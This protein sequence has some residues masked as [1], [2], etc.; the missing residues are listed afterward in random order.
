MIMI[1]TQYLLVKSYNNIIVGLKGLYITEHAF[2]SN[3]LKK[4]NFYVFTNCSK[5]FLTRLGLPTP[6]MQS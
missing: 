1:R 2:F 3:L 5:P 6:G 4:N